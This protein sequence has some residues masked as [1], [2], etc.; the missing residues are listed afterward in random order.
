[1]GKPT[2]LEE[3]RKLLDQL[4]MLV[5]GTLGVAAFQIANVFDASTSN[6]DGSLSPKQHYCLRDLSDK[7]LWLSEAIERAE[8]AGL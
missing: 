7:T 2:Q 1:M 3:A 8:E 5:G 4:G 6:S